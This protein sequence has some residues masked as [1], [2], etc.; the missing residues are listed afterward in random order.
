MEGIRANV[1]NEQYDDHDDDIGV[2]I[3]GRAV[4]DGVLAVIGNA[5]VR[6]DILAVVCVIVRSAVAISICANVME[7]EEYDELERDAR[8]ALVG[9]IWV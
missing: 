9:L 4:K 7:E 8:D 6:T 5:N 2:F 3:H 1:D